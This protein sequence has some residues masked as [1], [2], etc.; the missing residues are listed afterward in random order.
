MRIEENKVYVFSFN[1]GDHGD[2]AIPV[3]GESREA[4][5]NRLQN[6]F[7]SMQTELAMEFPKVVPG[8][9]SPPQEQPAI[10]AAEGL[11]EILLE[12][13]DKLLGDLGGSAL[14]GKAK[15]ETIKNWT[16]LDFIPENYSAIVKDL[17]LIASGQKEVPKP[18]K[19]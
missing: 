9:T 2:L 1:T 15:A 8:N 3:R 16:E 18:K 7:S 4:A 14:V 11:Q 10:P 17:E 19:K 12:R 13:I 6:M 5:A